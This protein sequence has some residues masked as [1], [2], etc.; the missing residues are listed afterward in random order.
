MKKLFMTKLL[1]AF[2]FFPLFY[3]CSVQQKA[4]GKIRLRFKK[5][6]PSL[7]FSEYFSIFVKS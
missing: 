7:A 3:S 2:I 6:F 1:F 4:D 5:T